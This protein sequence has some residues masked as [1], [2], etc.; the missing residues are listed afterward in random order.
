M[1]QK[2]DIC[3]IGTRG[4][5]DMEQTNRLLT[6]SILGCGGRGFRTYGRLMNRLADKFKIV[7]LC[8]TNADARL[9]LPQRN[10]TFRRT[11]VLR[12]TS[13]F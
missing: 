12:V 6:V 13:N 5:I 9:Q 4:G 7:A 8:D 3:D 1:R 11:I 10:L 2:S